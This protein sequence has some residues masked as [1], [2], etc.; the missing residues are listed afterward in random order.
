MQISNDDLGRMLGR[1]EAKLDEQVSASKRVEEA[2]A[3]VD[4]KVTQRLDEHDA[5]LR[6]LE[7]ANPEQLAKT[8][9]DHTKR[10]ES[11]EQGAARAGVVAGIASGLTVSVLAALA[12]AKLGL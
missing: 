9:S 10:I 6:R 2:V 11:L 3:S 8:L 7:V 5:R 12:R 1:M 4:R